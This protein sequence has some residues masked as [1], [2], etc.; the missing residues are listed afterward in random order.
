VYRIKKL[1]ASGQGPKGCRAVE[2]GKEGN[3]KVV[4]LYPQAPGSLYVVF[5]DSH[6]CDGGILTHLHERSFCHHTVSNWR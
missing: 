4:K 1:K 6:G 3:E 2:K 5:Y